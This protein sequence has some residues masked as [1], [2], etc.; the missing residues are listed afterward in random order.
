LKARVN[1]LL[2]DMPSAYL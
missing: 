1:M 2:S